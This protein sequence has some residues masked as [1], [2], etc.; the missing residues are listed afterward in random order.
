M[1][2]AFYCR[3][4]RFGLLNTPAGRTTGGTLV[5][6]A[7]GLIMRGLACTIIAML[8][9]APGILDRDIERKEQTHMKH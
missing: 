6:K 8:F 4:R 7:A 5:K 9:I 3:P 1:H 2:K